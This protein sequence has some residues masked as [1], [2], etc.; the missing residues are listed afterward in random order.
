MKLICL[1][2]DI[3]K[4]CDPLVLCGLLL[5]SAVVIYDLWICLPE[6]VRGIHRNTE[7]HV[8]QVKHVHSLF[9]FLPLPLQ[10]F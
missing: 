4:I 8:Q 7:E 5:G 6:R 3:R 2:W 10:T 1:Y 9:P